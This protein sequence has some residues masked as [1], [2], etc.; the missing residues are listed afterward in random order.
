MAT[1]ALLEDLANRWLRHERAFG[2]HEDFLAHDDEWLIC[3]LA[4]PILLEIFADL[5]PTWQNNSITVQMLTTLSFLAA[6]TFQRKL[7]DM[8]EIL[9]PSLNA[10]RQLS[11][12]A[13]SK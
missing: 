7:A 1:L 2:E 11:W 6:G 4:K 13:L 8:S 9:Q 3:R 10:N 5:G 12:M